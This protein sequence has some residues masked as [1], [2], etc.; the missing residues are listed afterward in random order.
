MNTNSASGIPR[1]Q[2][3][4]ARAPRTQREVYEW[5]EACPHLGV[6]LADGRPPRFVVRWRAGTG[7]QLVPLGAEGIELTRESAR[8]FVRKL[9]ASWGPA[10]PPSG[11]ERF[12]RARAACPRS[13]GL[14]AFYRQVRE[15]N[16]DFGASFR[17]LTQIWK[18]H[19][20][21]IGKVELDAALPADQD[22]Y[23]LHPVFLDA[24]L[25]VFGATLYEDRHR[26]TFIPVGMESFRFSR[27]PLRVAWSH[28]KL[29][30]PVQEAD[31]ATIADIEFFDEAWQYIGG[32]TGF[33]LLLGDEHSFSETDDEAIRRAL[34]EVTWQQ[35]EPA[36]GGELAP[37]AQKQAW[38][39]LSDQATT[40]SE[41]ALELQR[42]GHVVETLLLESPV[43][44]ASPGEQDTV[45]AAVRE[46]HRRH[47]ARFAGVIHVYPG[48]AEV[49]EPGLDT[50]VR[51]QRLALGA[52]LRSS[53]AL[54]ELES[55][56]RL[57]LWLVTHSAQCV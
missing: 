15:L 28:V 20:E 21:A 5:D 27:K 26:K 37:S 9:V 7:E 25:Q 2:E 50:L 29:R 33:S 39:L 17:A 11:T 30:V 12:I 56:T 41:L 18:G 32:I 40:A 19:Y 14:D 35:S 31:T 8:D 48:E 53:Q 10:E 43:E 45:S 34:Y 38:L 16:I 52:V 1:S 23:L 55:A 47:G 49:A 46:Q 22:P 51:R 13:I 4:G 3:D 6:R 42:R 36:Q 24:C 44:K 57:Q 54:L